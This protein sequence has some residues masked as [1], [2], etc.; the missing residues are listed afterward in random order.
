MGKREGLRHLSDKVVAQ[1]PNL[2][3]DNYEITSPQDPRYNCIAYA[4]GDDS[5]W[6]EPITFPSPGYYW[7]EGAQRG[8]SPDALRSCFEAVGYEVCENGE[9]EEGY[10]K[11][12]LYAAPNGSWTHAAGQLESGQ[13]TSKL[14][15]SVD[16]RHRIPG[17]VE[18]P[19]YGDI[20]IFMRTEKATKVGI[21]SGD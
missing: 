14:G 3:R 1:F 17:C 12:A 5:R 4:A 20:V 18:G 2:E 16:I 15:K 9:P 6:W 7:P 8:E 10:T 11:V 19:V 13:W 21:S